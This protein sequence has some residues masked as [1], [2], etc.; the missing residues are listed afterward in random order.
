MER[1]CDTCRDEVN[2]CF[3]V[4]KNIKIIY[5]QIEYT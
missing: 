5:L 1:T 4:S 3:T 2:T